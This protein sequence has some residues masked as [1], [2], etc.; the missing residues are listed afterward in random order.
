MFLLLVRFDWRTVLSQ[1]NSPRLLELTCRCRNLKNGT[2]TP[3]WMQELC[4]AYQAAPGN[5]ASPTKAGPQADVCQ[6]QANGPKFLQKIKLAGFRK[7]CSEASLNS[8]TSPSGS[9]EDRMKHIYA[10]YG[11]AANAPEIISSGEESAGDDDTAMQPVLPDSADSASQP[12]EARVFHDYA[13][14]KLMKAHVS[15]QLEAAAFVSK[16]GAFKW[17]QFADGSTHE[18]EFP[19]LQVL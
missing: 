5:E 7:G 18:T 8:S 9:L 11:I 4:L 13:A 12:S 16:P 14:G 2:R 15:G 3:V 10:Q 6:S 1:E 19:V 17:A